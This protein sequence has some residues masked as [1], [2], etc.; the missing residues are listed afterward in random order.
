MKFKN[1]LL[2]VGL[3]FSQSALA[4][5]DNGIT[6]EYIGLVFLAGLNQIPT[7]LIAAAFVTGMFFMAQSLTRAARKRKDNTIVP[8]VEIVRFFVGLA[9]CFLTGLMLLF[10]NFIF[11]GEEVKQQD[12]INRT[13]S[14]NKNIAR[15]LET[16][17]DCAE[18]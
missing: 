9:L 15:C 8:R 7:L 16:K 1:Y 6:L 13:M 2:L 3:I 4:A 10:G 12:M 18:Y 17:R 11:G 14:P 5:T